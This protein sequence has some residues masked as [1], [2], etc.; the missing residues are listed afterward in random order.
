MSKE[1]T[2]SRATPAMPGATSH[3]GPGS[4]NTGPA[5]QAARRAEAHRGRVAQRAYEL[6]EQRGRQEGRALD[7]WLNAERYLLGSAIQGQA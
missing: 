4:E 2:V 6:Y 5:E 7:D 1:T 3:A